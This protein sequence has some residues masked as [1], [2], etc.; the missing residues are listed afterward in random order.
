[1]GKFIAQ[2]FRQQR[3]RNKFPYPLNEEEVLKKV[4]P[5]YHQ[6]YIKPE[7]RKQV[8]HKS[9]FDKTRLRDMINDVIEYTENHHPTHV[10][11]EVKY[12][13]NQSENEK[14]WFLQK[15][16]KLRSE[17]G[18]GTVFQT[19][20]TGTLGSKT[21]MHPERAKVYIEKYKQDPIQVALRVK[22]HQLN[23]LRHSQEC[24]A[25]RDHHTRRY[26]S[27]FNESEKTNFETVEDILQDILHRK[28][29]FRKP[30]VANGTDELPF[31]RATLGEVLAYAF[32]NKEYFHC[33][34]CTTTRAD[35]E[36][37]WNRYFTCTPSKVANP[38]FS[39]ANFRNRGL[40]LNR[41]N[42]LQQSDLCVMELFSYVGNNENGRDR[43]Q[44][45]VESGLQGKLHKKLPLGT[46]G[47]RYDQA[48]HPV[49]NTYW[50]E[51]K[52]RVCKVYFVY[53]ESKL[54]Q[55]VEKGQLIINPT[56]REISTFNT[57]IWSRSTW[58]PVKLDL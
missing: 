45:Q 1:M 22:A 25:Q 48:G 55:S 5:Q 32:A 6:H 20:L 15:F 42:N 13:F 40:T 24:K 52:D 19:C 23:N 53:S 2:P 49:G 29:T 34:F 38:I 4:F 3:K 27:S 57:D 14:K 58:K 44:L 12:F 51:N 33:N 21:A 31:G 18:D 54:L 11:D 16:G 35:R 43:L 37:E 36:G 50:P 39:Q 28:D 8:L 30:D 26:L 46:L 41:L 47:F 17:M 7:N 10:V 56:R 9:F